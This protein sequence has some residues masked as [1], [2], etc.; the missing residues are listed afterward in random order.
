MNSIQ[1]FNSLVLVQ[2]LRDYLQIRLNQF[3]EFLQYLASSQP[4][5]TLKRE[6]GRGL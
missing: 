5:K 1:I 3:L 6:E 2:L 4:K